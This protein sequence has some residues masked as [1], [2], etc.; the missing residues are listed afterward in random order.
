MI[1]ASEIR[2][3]IDPV[4]PDH[5]STPNGREWH[6]GWEGFIKG[7]DRYLLER[8]DGVWVIREYGSRYG[9]SDFEWMVIELEG[10]TI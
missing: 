9:G 8:T 5:I 1:T 10:K 2:H 4:D 6:C 7:M 3:I